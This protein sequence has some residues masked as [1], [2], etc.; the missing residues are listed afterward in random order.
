MQVSS[1]FQAS[2]RKLRI[3]VNG[4]EASSSGE[5]EVFLL[6]DLNSANVAVRDLRQ[7]DLYQPNH[8]YF[9]FL[10]NIISYHDGLLHGAAALSDVLTTVPDGGE[11]VECLK[12]HYKNFPDFQAAIE[13][14]A[15]DFD[16]TAVAPATTVFAEME[17]LG[18]E[19]HLEDVPTGAGTYWR[20]FLGRTIGELTLKSV[21][22]RRLATG[23]SDDIAEFN[24]ILEDFH[25]S[26][27]IVSASDEDSV[28]EMD[29][30]LDGA[31]V[32]TE[33]DELVNR[34]IVST[35]PVDARSPDGL[36][37][38]ITMSRCPVSS[39]SYIIG[40]FQLVSRQ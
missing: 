17:K 28:L 32:V 2:A 37:G 38:S 12:K 10:G 7:S 3:A 35:V 15:V 26:Y 4:L 34:Q 13:S 11:M 8:L 21:T 25:G 31:N 20:E 36:S 22:I 24:F 5:A 19:Y 40:L 16:P 39:C 27:K 1:L 6:E 18:F 14:T 23:G 30:T 33:F 29:L 9:A